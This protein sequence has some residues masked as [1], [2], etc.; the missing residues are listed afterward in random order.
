LSSHRQKTRRE[1]EQVAG[2]I[3]SAGYQA[4]KTEKKELGTAYPTVEMNTDEQNSIRKCSH[5]ICDE[6]H[7]LR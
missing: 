5:L 3:C 1:N 2:V 4:A 6:E 7:S